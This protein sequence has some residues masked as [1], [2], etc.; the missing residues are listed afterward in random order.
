MSGNIKDDR[1]VARV[2]RALRSCGLDG[3]PRLVNIV[4]GEMSRVGRGRSEI[5]IASRRGVGRITDGPA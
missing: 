4:K 3:P 1:R 5:V 2:G